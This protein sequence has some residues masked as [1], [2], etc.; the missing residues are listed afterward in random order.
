MLTELQKQRRV[1]FARAFLLHL[2]Q[3]PDGGLTYLRHILWTDEVGVQDGCASPTCVR[4]STQSATSDEVQAELAAA[5][6]VPRAKV[7]ARVTV[8]LG[9]CAAAPDQ[10]NPGESGPRLCGPVFP[11]DYTDENTQA[12][13]ERNMTKVIYENIVRT[14]VGPFVSSALDRD[15]DK[16]PIVFQQ[17][18]LPAH[19][20][21]YLWLKEQR[22]G[23]LEFRDADGVDVGWPP[24]S[25]DLNIIENVWAVLKRELDV[26]KQKAE[27][28][29]AKELQQSVAQLLKDERVRRKFVGMVD[30]ACK[31]FPARLQAVIDAGGCSTRW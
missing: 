27:I 4:V 8:W 26:V 5:Q 21:G 6:Q 3:Q 15:K 10:V 11:L 25:P 14:C 24:Q 28:R 12:G 19:N 7:P 22:V 20:A 2:K 29:G 31:S 17:D 13:S 30:A 18:N 23:V 1:R 16:K 9:V